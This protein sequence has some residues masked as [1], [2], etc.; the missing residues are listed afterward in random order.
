MIRKERQ[1]VYVFNVSKDATKST[2]IASIKHAYKVTPESIRLL[3]VPKKRVFVRGKHG[4]KSGGKK[5]YI[6]LKKGDKIEVM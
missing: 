6:Y 2:I 1:N 3:A 5:A 4:V